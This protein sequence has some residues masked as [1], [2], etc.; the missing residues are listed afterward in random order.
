[1]SP[2]LNSGFKNRI[3]RV[4]FVPGWKT[5]DL[6]ITTMKSI[7]YTVNLTE[8]GGCNIHF[9]V[10]DQKANKICHSDKTIKVCEPKTTL[11]RNRINL[12]KPSNPSL[13]PNE[14][15]NR[16]NQL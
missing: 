7:Q 5:L 13:V 15:D 4:Y 10:S 16:K 11:Q 12:S 6:A 9:Q 1:M 14:E 3:N 2:F 8:M